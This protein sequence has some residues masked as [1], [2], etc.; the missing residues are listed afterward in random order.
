LR[1]CHAVLHPTSTPCRLISPQHHQ[2]WTRPCMCLAHSASERCPRRFVSYPRHPYAA[3]R[4]YFIVLGACFPK[5]S[6]TVNICQVLG[7]LYIFFGKMS[8]Q[9]FCPCLIWQG[10]GSDVPCPP[11]VYVLRV[12]SPVWW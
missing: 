12:W 1:S 5:W 4:C 9:V 3:M 10:S 2:H 7:H 8:V 11:R 6:V